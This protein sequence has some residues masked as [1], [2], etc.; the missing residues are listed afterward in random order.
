[1]PFAGNLANTGG[2]PSMEAYPASLRAKLLAGDQPVL[3]DQA[4]VVE[5]PPSQ[6]ATDGGGIDATTVGLVGAL[7]LAGLLLFTARRRRHM[8][9][10]PNAA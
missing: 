8:V 10:R 4:Q 5:P 7:A 1:M 3:D 6:G 9:G 2:N